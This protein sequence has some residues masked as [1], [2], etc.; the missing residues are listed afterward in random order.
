MAVALKKVKI[1]DP[2][3]LSQCGGDQ[4]LNEVILRA[5]KRTPPAD[6]PTPRKCSRT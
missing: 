2:A 4:V 6:M 3:A 5:W 1:P